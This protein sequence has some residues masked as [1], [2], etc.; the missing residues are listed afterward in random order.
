M[1][2]QVTLHWQAVAMQAL[3]SILVRPFHDYYSPSFGSGVYVFV[4]STKRGFYPYYVGESGDIGNRIFYHLKSYGG[5]SGDNYFAPRS[6]DD[7]ARDPYDYIASGHLEKRGETFGEQ[8][9]QREVKKL[10]RNTHF[11]F[12]RVAGDAAQRQIVES[13]LIAGLLDK[14]N[15]TGKEKGKGWIGD[16]K[17]VTVPETLKITHQCVD[18]RVKRFLERVWP[19]F[20]P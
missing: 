6:F 19:V 1:E 8:D 20:L 14:V 2:I 11:C 5:K 9:Y 15:P 7:F 18:E 16:A 3:W 10:I 4:L 12:A 17:T 13:R